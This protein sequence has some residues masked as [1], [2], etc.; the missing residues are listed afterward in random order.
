MFVESY[1]FE[2]V[3]VWY[4]INMWLVRNEDVYDIW[5]FRNV[6]ILRYKK[7]SK[8]GLNELGSSSFDMWRTLKKQMICWHFMYNKKKTKM[9]IYAV[10]SMTEK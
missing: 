9:K 8:N 3:A 1:L 7:N 10:T 4:Q 6:H 2:Y 5:K